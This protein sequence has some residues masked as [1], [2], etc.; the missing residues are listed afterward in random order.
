MMSKVVCPNCQKV[1]PNNDVIDDAA[2]GEG[3]YLREVICECGERM[4]FWQIKALLREQ[5]TFGW[6]LRKMIRSLSRSSG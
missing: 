3:S 5:N 6:K 1:L 4:T 2:K